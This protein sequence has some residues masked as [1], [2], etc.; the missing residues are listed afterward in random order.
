MEL[1]T[2]EGQLQVHFVTKQEQYAVPDMPY[3]I[4]ANITTDELNTLVNTLIDEDASAEKATEFDF[5][6]LGEFLK[7]K[8]G[9]HLKERAVSFEDVVRIEYVERF[10]APEPQDC[11]LHDDW[12]S[13][14]K[15]ND[16]WILTGCY[17]NTVNLWT[18]KGKHV[19]TIPGHTAPIKAVAWV[20]LNEQ[21]GVFA[22]ASQD[23]TAMIWQW[24]I[25]TNTVECVSVCKGHERGIDCIDTSPSSRLIAT[26]S[27]DN[28]LKVW[29]TAPHDENGES[30]SK[31]A[32]TEH[33]RTISPVITLKGH[34]EAISAVQW[35]NEETILTS[36]WDHTMRVW[37]LALEGIKLEISGNKS[38]FDM[39]YSQLNGLIITA[40][41]DKNLRL[42]DS[43]TNSGNVVK[44]TYYGHAAWV[45]SVCWSNTDEH[46]FIS[47]AHDNMVKLWDMRSAK[48]P[49]FDLIGHE[50]KVHDCDWSNPK[51][52][53]SGG[54]DNSVRIFK[55]KKSGESNNE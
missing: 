41:A 37:D 15:A 38:F 25:A 8:L 49:L 9:D 32:K 42:Y 18:T 30:D 19:L 12:V 54:A 2:G 45:Q 22:S 47:G 14:V 3:S 48:A 27:W 10:P 28:L 26:G 24:N 39:S 6:V 55:S 33:G 20:S 43:R 11:L 51:Y 23:Q 44:N 46:L 31:K 21:T 35:I 17:D 13:A 1:D 5:L 7:Q 40:S 36:S 53:V 16:K 29:A 52:M 4:A 50:D 34:R